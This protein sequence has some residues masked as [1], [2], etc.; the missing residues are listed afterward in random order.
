MVSP[1]AFTRSRSGGS[2]TF[3]TGAYGVF[4]S[5]AVDGNG[6]LW[7][8]G[9]SAELVLIPHGSTTGEIVSVPGYGYFNGVRLDAANDLYASTGGAVAVE[10]PTG[11]TTPTTFGSGISYTEGVAV[12]GSG[13]VFVGQSSTVPG[14]GKVY[15]I[16][17]GVQS[18]YTS[19]G[20]ATTGGLALWPAQIPASRPSSSVAL[21]SNSPTTVSTQTS[22]TVTAT[23]STRGRRRGPVRRQREHD[24]RPGRRR[25]GCRTADDGPAG[26]TKQPHRNLPR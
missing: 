14:Y 6:N 7:G 20:L 11:S 15:E 3:V 17:G 26:W 4:T 1:K 25:R 23:E 22:V 21:T 10:L 2:P 13:N 8:A 18:V 9:G 24:R 12:D 5:L 16:S 19:G